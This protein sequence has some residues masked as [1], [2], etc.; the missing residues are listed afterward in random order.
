MKLPRL[1]LGAL[2]LPFAASPAFA[3]GIVAPEPGTAT[4]LGAA[5][6]GAVLIARLLK[7]R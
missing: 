2:V 7:G 5:A 1:V 6:V 3:G 4:L